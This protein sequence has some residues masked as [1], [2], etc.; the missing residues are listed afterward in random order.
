MLVPRR[1]GSLESYKYGFQGQEKDDEIKGEGN[2][3]DFGA[4]MFDSRIGRFFTKDPKWRE[5]V[6]QSVYAYALNNPIRFI[7]LFGEGPGDRVKAARKFLKTKYKQ[8]TELELR[9]GTSKNA[10]E[11]MDCS[12]LICRVLAADEF[13]DG[14]KSLPTSNS[15]LQNWLN[16]NGWEETDMPK[17][18]DIIVWKGHTALVTADYEEGKKIKV[19]HATKYGTVEEVVEES[20]KK[21][22]Y[23]GKKAKFYRPINDKPDG[24]LEESKEKTNKTGVTKNSQYEKQQSIEESIKLLQEKSESLMLEVRSLM[25]RVENTLKEIENSNNEKQCDQEDNLPTCDEEE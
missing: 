10:L 2:S 3:L 13:T 5:Y 4:R 11:Y 25:I 9:T 24:D 23:D 19:I 22:Y 1:H 8:Q 7:D 20:Y 18:G 12:E 14:V 21:S 6:F 17:K 16:S 15:A